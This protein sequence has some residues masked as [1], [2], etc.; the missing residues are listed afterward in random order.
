MTM[1]LVMMALGADGDEGNKP[2]GWPEYSTRVW[3]SLKM[4]KWRAIVILGSNYHLMVA[5]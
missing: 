3:S 5:R 1:P 2:K 4:K